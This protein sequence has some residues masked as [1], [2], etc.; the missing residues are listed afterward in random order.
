GETRVHPRVIA[1]PCEDVRVDHAGA[2]D[3]QPAGLLAEP[4]SAPAAHR[5]V[6]RHVDAGLDER[7]VVAAKAD[8]PLPAEEAPGELEE[9]PLEVGH[10]D[11]AIDGEPLDLVEHTL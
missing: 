9:R 3:L 10:R 7:E 4:A 1:H 5:A 6:D 2:E 11:A 8:A